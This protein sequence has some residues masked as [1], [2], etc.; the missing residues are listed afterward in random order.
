MVDDGVPGA[1]REIR[2]LIAGAVD[3]FLPDSQEDIMHEIACSGAAADT[4]ANLTFEPV[5]FRCIQ[6]CYF[7]RLGTHSCD[8][9]TGAAFHHQLG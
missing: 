1:T 4:T 9:P 7:F 6:C 5:V 2:G 3:G 8:K